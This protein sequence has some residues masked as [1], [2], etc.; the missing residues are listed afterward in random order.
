MRTSALLCWILGVALVGLLGCGKP[1]QSV[2]ATPPGAQ[3][4]DASK[5]RPAFAAAPAETQAIV[6]KVMLAL[7]ASDYVGALTE[8]E[9]LTNSPGLTPSQQ[10]VVADLSQQIQ[11][12][13]VSMPAPSQ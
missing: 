6:N 1:A 2:D 3:F 4:I 9:S 13:L 12:K 10:T 11:K 8:L 7:G 5:F